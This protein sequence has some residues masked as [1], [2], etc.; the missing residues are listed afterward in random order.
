M[1]H[2]LGIDHHHTFYDHGRRPMMVLP[3]GNPI[4]ELIG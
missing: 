3:E 2:T 4:P 1:Y